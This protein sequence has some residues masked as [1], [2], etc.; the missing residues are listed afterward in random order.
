MATMIDETVILRY[1]LNDNKRQTDEAAATIASGTTLVYPE[2]IA[3]T[4]VSLRDVYH[5]PRSVIGEALTRLLEDVTV[6]DEAAVRLAIRYFSSTLLDF[7]DCLMVARNVL[8]G[9]RV[10]SFDKAILKKMLPV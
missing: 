10:V 6:V 4:A 8:C 2:I 5:V 1:L 9:H 7:T 3:R